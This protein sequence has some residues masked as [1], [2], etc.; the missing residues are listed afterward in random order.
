MRKMILIAFDAAVYGGFGLFL[1]AQVFAMPG[2]MKE[3]LLSES[4]K[5]I[6]KIVS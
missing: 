6:T 2:E 5:L 4:W 3:R 1:I